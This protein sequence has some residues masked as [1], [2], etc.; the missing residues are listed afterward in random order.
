MH[1]EEQHLI[2]SLRLEVHDKPFHD[3]ESLSGD[4]I[5]ALNKTLAELVKF[6]IGWN[7]YDL[8]RER[9]KDL[10]DFLCF[11]TL[12]IRMVHFKHFDLSLQPFNPIGAG[13]ISRTQDDQ[14]FETS[15]YRRLYD[16]IKIP[17]PGDYGVHQSGKE[18]FYLFH[19]SLI[20]IRIAD[21][22]FQ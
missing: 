7:V 1:Y 13:I 9:A 17:Y 19:F 21:H 8:I 15:V 5:S 11:H 6:Q 2:R 3:K 4:V 12:G 18:T 16:I 22:K 10:L 14:L 20:L